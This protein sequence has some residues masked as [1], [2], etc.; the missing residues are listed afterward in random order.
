MCELREQLLVNINEN[1]NSCLSTPNLLDNYYYYNFSSKNESPFNYIN[2]NSNSEVNQSQIKNNSCEIIEETLNYDRNEKLDN[3]NQS[4]NDVNTNYKTPEKKEQIKPNDINKNKIVLNKNNLNENLNLEYNNNKIKA[5]LCKLELNDNL[6]SNLELP[7]EEAEKSFEKLERK[8]KKKKLKDEKAEGNKV[9]SNL[10]KKKYREELNQK[11]EEN[12]HNKFFPSII[13]KEIK[14]FFFFNIFIFINNIAK[15]VA[16]YQNLEIIEKIKENK[17]K[18]LIK[19]LDYKSLKQD[20]K[21][22]RNEKLL[23]MKLIDI[24]VENNISSK[25]KVKSNWNKEIVD[26]I[27]NNGNCNKVIKF[28]FELTYREWINIFTYKKELRDFPEADDEIINGINANFVRIDKA[29]NKKYGKKFDENFQSFLLFIYNYEEY[30]YVING[31]S[32]RKKDN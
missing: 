28:A 29:L 32:R 16:Y 30:F 19:S 25:N 22:D 3:L 27:Y 9:F 11:N 21:K 8:Y 24:I 4:I 15:N 5:I 1:N 20:L 17:Y 2:N 10:G 7:N 14:V 23:N 18:K 12:K 6:K 13:L 26:K 31:R